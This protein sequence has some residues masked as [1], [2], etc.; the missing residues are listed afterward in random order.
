MRLKKNLLQIHST[1][2]ASALKAVQISSERC[3]SRAVC[4][5]SMCLSLT[6]DTIWMYIHGPRYAD[7]R[8][9]NLKTKKT[10]DMTILSVKVNEGVVV[11]WVYTSALLYFMKWLEYNCIPW[12]PQGLKPLI[13]LLF[14]EIEFASRGYCFELFLFHQGIIPLSCLIEQQV[15]VL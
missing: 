7:D 6:I 11:S 10:I 3:V 1:L 4:Y 2:T 5:C 8:N 13:M 15:S 9:L 12:F 14:Q